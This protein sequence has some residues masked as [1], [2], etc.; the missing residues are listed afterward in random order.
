M[1]TESQR[2]ADQLHRAYAGGAW[3]GP[4]LRQLLRGVS[5]KQAAARPI[6]GAHTIWELVLHITAWTRAVR[7]RMEGKPTRLSPVENFPP[8]PKAT[9]ANWKQTLDALRTAQYDLHRAVSAVPASRLK[10]RVPGKRY[11]LYFM[12]HGLVQHDLYH[13]GQIALLKKAGRR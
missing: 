1:S 12:L 9:A 3:H 6:R 10:K 13:A 7:R 2:I 5:A 8:M 11:S 4:A